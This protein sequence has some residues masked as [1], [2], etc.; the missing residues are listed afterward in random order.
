[1]G[2]ARRVRHS[3][4]DHWPAVAARCLYW[5]WVLKHR[6]SARRALTRLHVGCGRNRF[7]GWINADIDPRAD[8]VVFL[9]KRLPFPDGFLDRIYSEH[10]LEHVPYEIGLAF[11]KDARRTLKAGGVLRIAMPDLEDLVKGYYDGDW[12]TRFDWVQW[13]EYAFLCTRAQMLNVG[14]RWWGHQYLYDRE[15]LTRALAEAGFQQIAFPSHSESE[16]EDLRGLE[17]RADSWLVAE[18]IR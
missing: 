15:E 3:L 12:K 6:L 18:A 2:I 8:L 11:L 5:P 7:K 13:P 17:T 9:E 1:M 16:H 10:V 4:R 14:L